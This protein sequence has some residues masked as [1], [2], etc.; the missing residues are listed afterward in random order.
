METVLDIFRNDAFSVAALQR[1][2]ANMPFIP[3]LLGSMEL[4]DPQPL[5]GTDKV[6]MYEEDGSVR[7]I[8]FSE[9]GSPDAQQLR[10]QGRMYALQTRR[11]SKKDSVQASELL[12][13]A[14]MTLP[15]KI[16]IKRAATLV[17]KRTQALKNDMAMT[18][19]FHRIAAIQG[20]LLDADGTTVVYDYF[21]EFGVTPPTT[22]S[23]NFASLTED[24]T[25]MY[26]QETITRP[27]QL[28]LKNRWIIGRT[29]VGAL[30]GDSFWGKLMRN[31]AIRE[32]WKRQE[33]GR[34][35]AMSV[36]PL[37]KANMWEEVT[38][39]GITF[40][41]YRGSTLGEIAIADNTAIFFPIGAADVF[42]VYW[43]P[44]ETME[45]VVGEGQPEYLHIQPDTRS[46]MVSFVDIFVRAYP[47]Y[48]C[49]FPKA[50]LKA[51][52]T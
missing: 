51:T 13:I 37:L 41:N 32:S 46:Q 22:I 25:A 1:L 52:H 27:M 5:T 23:I 4:F 17:D 30:V 24:E 26:F 31:P 12:G 39:G 35:I 6:I 15:Q 21:A 43:A 40:I 9:R 19:E 14:D 16:R 8:P 34:Q 2:V 47:L 11:V 49:I 10:N 48:A 38:V 29:R 44:G 36:N 28:V 7:I 20:K 50:L 33:T 3:Q 42:N 45:T 18:K